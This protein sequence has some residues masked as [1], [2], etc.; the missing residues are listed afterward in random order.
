[1]AIRWCGT[2]AITGASS[3]HEDRRRHPCRHARA[4]RRG[5]RG[6]RAEGRQL[7]RHDDGQ[8]RERHHVQRHVLEP[9]ARQRHLQVHEPPSGDAA[10]TRWKAR[11]KAGTLKGSARTTLTP[12]A[13]DADPPTIDGAGKVTGGTDRYEG[14][15]GNLVISGGGN[16]DGTLT[17]RI[18]GL[19]EL[20]LR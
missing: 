2:A 5:G 20:A 7:H 17:L 11:L 1:M 15:K 10:V 8:A 13:S 12:G 19:L 3:D 18:D 6:R 9:P 4:R 16:P 14:A